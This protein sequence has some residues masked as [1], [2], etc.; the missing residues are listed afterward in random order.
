MGGTLPKLV[1]STTVEFSKVKAISQ[2]TSSKVLSVLMALHFWSL[3]KA[4]EK[5]TGSPLKNISD[6]IP[7]TL[8]LPRVLEMLNCS[9]K[10]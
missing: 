5:L 9:F 10:S 4:V 6:P 1:S 3:K 2:A 8:M 7:V